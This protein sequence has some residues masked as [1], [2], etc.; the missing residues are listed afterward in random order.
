MQVVNAFSY[1]ENSLPFFI[2]AY[3]DIAALE[4]VTQRLSGFEDRLVAIH[5]L[6]PAQRQINIRHGGVGVAVHGVDLDLPDGKALL[7]GV[8]FESARGEAV[9][10]T[11]PS[12][13]GNSTLLRALA[14]LWPFSG[15]EIRLG[16][17]RILFVPQRPYLPLDT[18]ASALVYPYGDRASFPAARLTAALEEVGLGAL[19]SE[20]DVVENWSQRLSLEGLPR[21]DRGIN[22]RFARPAF[23]GKPGSDGESSGFLHGLYR[24]RIFGGHI[25]SERRGRD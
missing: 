23:D 15:C 9:L 13:S 7:P 24:N 22:K 5:Q 18:L 20:L 3:P 19:A 1:V 21:A 16:E 25:V 12:G 2:N 11:G 10:I 4:A 8:S 14:G 17:G 6:I